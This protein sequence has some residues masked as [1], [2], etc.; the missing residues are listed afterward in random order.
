MGLSFRAICTLDRWT[1][2]MLLITHFVCVIVCVFCNFMFY[3][4]NDFNGIETRL[5]KCFYVTMLVLYVVYYGQTLELIFFP[6]VTFFLWFHFLCHIFFN[7]PSN[8]SFVLIFW[9]LSE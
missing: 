6:I 2:A 8:Q 3:I 4:A 1:G 5:I 9:V 7:D